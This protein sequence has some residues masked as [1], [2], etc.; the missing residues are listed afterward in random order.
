VTELRDRFGLIR[1]EITREHHGG[2]AHLVITVDADWQEAQGLRVAYSPDSGGAMWTTVDRLYDLLVSDDGDGGDEYVPTAHDELVEAVLNGN[3][4]RAK[5]LVA[6]GADINALAAD[7]YPPLCMA[8]DQMEVEEV[9]RLLAF[10]ADPNLPDPD[11]KKTPLKMAKRMYKEMGFGPVKKKDALHDA[12]A[13]LA[14][15][16][17]G[18]P[19]DDVRVRLEEIIQLLTAAG[20]K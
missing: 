7:E 18:K 5:A 14:R 11:E 19:I 2:F 10:G 8:V 13:A 16:A 3:E 20:G 1:V 12:M 17:T 4:A 6:A 9:R 15:E